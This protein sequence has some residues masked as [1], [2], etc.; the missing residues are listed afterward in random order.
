[1]GAERCVPIAEAE[2]NVLM[3]ISCSEWV[4]RDLRFLGWKKHEQDREL[5]CQ[6]ACLG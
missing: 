5:M 3:A 6:I 2:I 1:M 4:K